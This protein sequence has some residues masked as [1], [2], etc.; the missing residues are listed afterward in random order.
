ML[1]DEN[2]Q[3]RSKVSTKN[4][5]EIQFPILNPAIAAIVLRHTPRWKKNIVDRISIT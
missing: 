3:I 4:N 1:Y 2:V 5:R